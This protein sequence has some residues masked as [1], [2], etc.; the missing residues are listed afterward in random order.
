MRATGG[1]MAYLLIEEDVQD[2]AQSDDYRDCPE[3]KLDE[4]KPFAVHCG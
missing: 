3:L 4:M 1:K 2:L